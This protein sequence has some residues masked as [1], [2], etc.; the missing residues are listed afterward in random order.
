VL[1]EW[2]VFDDGGV[3]RFQQRGFGL[4]DS[5]AENVPRCGWC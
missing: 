4:F 3:R 2:I 5:G 1:A